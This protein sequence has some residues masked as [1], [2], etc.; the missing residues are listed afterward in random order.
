MVAHIDDE[1]TFFEFVTTSLLM[2][3]WLEITGFFND[4][5]KVIIQFT[6]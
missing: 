2:L 3:N 5:D 6:E 4:M 1:N